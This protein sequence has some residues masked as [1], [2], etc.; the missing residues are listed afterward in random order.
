MVKG[1]RGV[2]LRGFLSSWHD[3]VKGKCCKG[4][5]GKNFWSNVLEVGLPEVLA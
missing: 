4:E 5:E 3:S 1:R 2:G